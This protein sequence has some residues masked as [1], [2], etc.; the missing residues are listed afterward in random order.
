MLDG[1][2][3]R[4]LLAEVTSARDIIRKALKTPALDTHE[5]LAKRPATSFNDDGLLVES[6]QRALGANSKLQTPT[7]Q[8]LMS[9]CQAI[10]SMNEAEAAKLL[11]RKAEAM[12]DYS[13]WTGKDVKD[14]LLDLLRAPPD[15]KDVEAMAKE[16]GDLLKRCPHVD[17][18]TWGAGFDETSPFTVSQGRALFKAIQ[19]N[20]TVKRLSWINQGATGEGVAPEMAK[21]IEMNTVLQYFDVQGT[22]IPE[23]GGILIAKALET[24]TSL[25]EVVLATNTE[26]LGSSESALAFA[27]AIEKNA[28]LVSLNLWYTSCYEGCL[29]DADAAL[30]AKAL[31]VNTSLKEFHINGDLY[32]ELAG[33]AFADAMEANKTLENLNLG[34][35]ERFTD[36]VRERVQKIVH[37]RG[38]KLRT[39]IKLE[40]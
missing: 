36:D 30:L 21:A 31:G 14:R 16:V 20:S 22:G 17:D 5:A 1:G 40:S 2:A 33:P 8:I 39:S 27:S 11:R 15:P 7:M 26:M 29:K 10:D 25:K 23:A 18:L 38:G 28:G 37:G 12:A 24:N 34:A 6:I 19:G 32:G 9:A 13:T 4:D 3:W 35:C